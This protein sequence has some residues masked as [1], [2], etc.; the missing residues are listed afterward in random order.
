MNIRFVNSLVQP[1][2]TLTVEERT[3]LEDKLRDLPRKPDRSEE[4]QKLVALQQKILARRQGKPF[5]PPLDRYLQE[6]RDE[7]T[8]IQDELVID[9]FSRISRKS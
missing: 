7:R 2:E 3:L 4:N 5:D 1:I 9:C 6:G 8:A